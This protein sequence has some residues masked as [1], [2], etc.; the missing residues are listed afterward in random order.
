MNQRTRIKICGLTRTD[1]IE[2]ITEAGADA[3]GLVFHP[4][5]PRAL[6]RT[7]ARALRA[8]IPAFVSTVAL[9]VNPD[10]TTVQTVLRDVQP[11]ALQFHGEESAPFCESFGRP[12]IK[13]FRVGGPG[14]DTPAGL[15]RACQTYS[16]ASAWLFDS[17][18]PQYGGSGLSFDVALLQDICRLQARRPIILSG[19]L[20]ADNVSQRLADA[21]AYAVDVSSGVESAPGIKDCGKV[22]EFTQAVMQA[23]RKRSSLWANALSP[24]RSHS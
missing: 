8:Q 14:L 22:L 20:N 3:I 1:D 11:D 19:G 9:F 4:T 15:V 21:C 10:A 24:T 16:S 13:A 23:D 2:P 7:Q 18:S 5:S 12:Y 17:Y 6:T